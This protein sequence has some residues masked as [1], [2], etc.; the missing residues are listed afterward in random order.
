MVCIKSAMHF[1]DKQVVSAAHR[2]RSHSKEFKREL[3][4]RSLEPGVSVAAIAM[5]NGI[6]ANLLFGW[7]RKHLNGLTST[8][9]GAP[10]QPAARLLPVSIEET[11]RASH[12]TSPSPPTR[13]GNGTIEIEIGSAR[14][15]LRGNVASAFAGFLIPVRLRS[16]FGDEFLRRIA[17]ARWSHVRGQRRKK[18]PPPSQQSPTTVVGAVPYR[19]SHTVPPH[20]ARPD[21]CHRDSVGAVP[22]PLEGRD[23]RARDMRICCEL[24]TPQRWTEMTARLSAICSAASAAIFLALSLPV[25]RSADVGAIVSALNL[26]PTRY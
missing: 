11:S 19:S 4:A 21:L 23:E 5:D 22:M 25:G 20:T 16:G 18:R 15:R 6:N 2:R 10:A 1:M 12:R 8:D 3:V 24:Q 17:D 13:P 26:D 7:R 9:A 14:V